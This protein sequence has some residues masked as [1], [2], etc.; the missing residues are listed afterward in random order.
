MFRSAYYFPIF[1][2]FFYAIFRS[3]PGLTSG[4]PTSGIVDL[5][6]QITVFV[7]QQEQGRDR[8]YASKTL[9]LKPNISAATGLA[10]KLR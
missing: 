9:I 4:R 3:H 5:Y 7:H 6:V 1:K 10:D 8:K 2:G